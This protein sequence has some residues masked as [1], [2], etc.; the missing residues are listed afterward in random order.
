M[1]NS[2]SSKNLSEYDFFKN[3]SL[4]VVNNENYEE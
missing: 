4:A 2:L 3:N 1:K